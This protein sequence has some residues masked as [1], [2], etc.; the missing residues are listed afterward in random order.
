VS[1]EPEFHDDSIE[2]A[3]ITITKTFTDEVEGGSAIFTSYSDGLG[4]ADALGM[5]AFSQVMTVRE[6]L[7]DDESA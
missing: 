7:G 1:Q 6:Y 2:V 3:R 5:L 4:L